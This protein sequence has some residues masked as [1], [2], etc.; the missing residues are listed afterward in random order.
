MLKEIL[1]TGLRQNNLTQKIFSSNF[2]RYQKV[3]PKFFLSS[4]AQRNIDLERNNQI[5]SALKEKSFVLK[6]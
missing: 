5:D 4:R 2:N 1:S 6:K 3:L